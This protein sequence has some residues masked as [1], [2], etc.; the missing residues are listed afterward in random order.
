MADDQTTKEFACAA[1]IVLTTNPID[2]QYRAGASSTGSAAAVADFQCHVA[3]GTQTVS[4][5]INPE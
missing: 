5:L 4:G 3:L 1:S 2:A